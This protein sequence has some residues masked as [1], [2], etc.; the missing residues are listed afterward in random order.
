MNRGKLPDNHSVAPTTLFH[1]LAYFTRKRQIQIDDKVWWRLVGADLSKQFFNEGTQY[2]EPCSVDAG[3][4]KSAVLGIG[5]PEFH[6]LLMR[7]G[8]IETA[9][10]LRPRRGYT[11]LMVR[12]KFYLDYLIKSADAEGV[13]KEAASFAKDVVEEYCS[14]F[15]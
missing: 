15:R 8:K 4:L 1:G 9:D 3:E 5:A 6:E 14:M 12:P 13:T 7:P 10:F 2:F 11:D